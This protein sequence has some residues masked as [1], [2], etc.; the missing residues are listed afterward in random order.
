MKKFILI[1]VVLT[2]ALLLS[3][4]GL[5]F[6]TIQP[7]SPVTDNSQSAGAVTSDHDTDAASPSPDPSSSP[8]PDPSPSSVPYG[9]TGMELNAPSDGSDEASAEPSASEAVTAEPETQTPLTQ[10][11]LD[12]FTDYFSEYGN[13]GFLLSDY[14]AV[15]DVDFFEL[16]YVGAGIEGVFDSIP[17]EEVDA[18]LA[19]IGNDGVYLSLMKLTQQ[20]VTDFLYEKTGKVFPPTNELDGWIYLEQYDAFYTEVSDTNYNFL[21]CGSG[22]KTSSGLYVIHF[23][24]EEGYGQLVASCTATLYKDGDRYLIVSNELV[25]SY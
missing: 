4:C 6:N 25:T 22:Y 15:A 19:A 7:S 2:I 11:E 3:A 1:T 21:I 13:N 16:F 18:Y 14:D 20:Q 12:Y 17:Q 5:I 9:G 10:E 24:A 8:S 23:I